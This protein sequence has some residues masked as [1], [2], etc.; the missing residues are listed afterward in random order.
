MMVMKFGG[1]SV[2]SI[3]NIKHIQSIAYAKKEP[4]IMV[5]S[6]LSSSTDS[7]EQIALAAL[8]G[9]YQDLID[10]LKSKHFNLIYECF[11][12][13]HQTEVVVFCQQQFNT[14][15]NICQGIHILSELSNKIKAR[16]L[17]F[18]EQLSAF[19][20]HKYLIQ[21]GLEI[22]LLD[23]RPLIKANHNYLNGEVNLESSEKLIIEKIKQKNYITGGFMGSNHK[24]ETVLLG[25]GGSDYTAAI[26][27][28]ALNASH[29][30][31]WSDVNGMQTAN[32]KLVSNPMLIEKLSYKEAF[33]LAYFGAKVLYP[34]SIR[35]VRDKNIPLY[36]KNT[37]NPEQAGTFISINGSDIEQ[38]I[39]GV[40][41][42][43][44]IS[45]LNITGVGLAQKKGT[46]RRVFQAIEEAE[47]NVILITQSCSEQS[48]CLG[49]SN[50]DATRAKASLNKAFKYEISVGLMNPLEISNDYAIVAVIGDNMKNRVG[51]SGQVF[52][53]L[54][55]NGINITAIAQGSSER[56]ISI[57]INKKDEAKAVHVLH[58]KFF[59]KTI[60]QI[61][62]FIAGV[63]NV[64]SSF[65]NV[66][67]KQHA[68]LLEEYQIN[69]KIIGVANSTKMLFNEG[70]LNINAIK[71][72]KDKGIAYQSFDDFIHK[73]KSFNL[74]NSIFIDNTASDI[75]SKAYAFMLQNSISV[76]A[77]NKIACSGSYS[78]YKHLLQLAKEHNCHFKYETSVGAALPIIKTIQDLILS[79]DRI[80]KIQAVL[81][82]SLN[83]IFNEY[84]GQKPFSDIVLQA[85]TEGYT[86]PNPLIDLSGLDVM[87]KILILS[88]EAGFVKEMTDISFKG[89]LP[90]SCNDASDL[91]KFFKEL[92]KNEEHFKNIYNEAH[93]KGCK[94]KV[95]A[96]LENG[97]LSVALN[98]ITPESSLF[99]LQ[100]KDN[101]VALH[102]ERYRNEPMIIKGAGAG[103][104]VTASGVFSDLMYIVNR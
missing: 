63:G 14:L 9:N 65:L 81:S 24:N 100:G 67:E 22:E 25:R 50:S 47:V 41:S 11:Q 18:G 33:E 64:G 29:L 78:N 35:P 89:F 74:R 54:G 27:A 70:G 88:R 66:I 49:I 38:T 32:P 23:S 3:K 79:G 59:E 42:L 15:E 1:T 61:H 83:F 52:R 13:A 82:G 103:A 36:L 31:I 75:V 34:P 39:Q 19:I 69:I 45:V 72:I 10:S 20:I 4:F 86:E 12:P 76:V 93:Q 85:K 48:I 56:N 104:A 43:A 17:S 5:V 6:A 94:L 58:E 99:N 87:R 90:E 68:H 60:K 95:V 53:A 62:L 92:L 101:V 21:E 2:S 57:I 26:Y 91:D 55:E 44:G 98:E 73:A 77:C 8:E 46:A 84:N 102:T 28:Y 80:F 71:N 97:H 16:I 40:S 51:L 7:L 96:T 37:L 30:E